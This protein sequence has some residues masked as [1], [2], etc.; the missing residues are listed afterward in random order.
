MRARAA[1]LSRA[2]RARALGAAIAWPGVIVAAVALV[3][4]DFAFGLHVRGGDLLDFFAP[5]HC[6]LGTSLRAGHIPAWN[7]YALAGVPFAAD[8]Q[9]GWLHLPAMFLYTALPCGAAAPMLVVLQPALAGVGLYAFL[10]G[11]RVSRPSAALGGLAL[12]VGTAGSTL[13]L[14]LPFAGTLAWTPWLLAAAGRALRAVRWSPRLAWT[15]A[16]AVAWGQL[17][18]AHASDGLFVGTAALL[19]YA[20]ATMWTA[21]GRDGRPARSFL[22][23]AGVLL[24]ALPLVNLAILVPRAAYLPRT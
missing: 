19:A 1:P 7:P 4:H 5:N 12:G 11:E 17:A 13:V 2:A 14:S 23:P 21:V 6:F 8:P 24:A 15:A 20:G 10:R 18:A 9:A 3:L 22:G 16:A